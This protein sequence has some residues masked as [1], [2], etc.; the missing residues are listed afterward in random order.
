[1]RRTPPAVRA[2]DSPP[3]PSRAAGR[4]VARWTCRNI[5]A[6]WSFMK[7]VTRRRKRAA[8]TLTMTEHRHAR[9]GFDVSGYCADC[10]CPRL[11]WDR[12]F[13]GRDRKD[14][15]LCCDHPVRDLGGFRPHPRPFADGSLNRLPHGF[16]ARAWLSPG[17]LTGRELLACRESIA[18]PRA[19][20]DQPRPPAE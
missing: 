2:C 9:L 12:G 14:H 1:M 6:H 10:G 19:T 11:W 20:V 16:Q 17:F 18:D 15:L 5:L 7:S 3:V 4:T 8:R 13:R